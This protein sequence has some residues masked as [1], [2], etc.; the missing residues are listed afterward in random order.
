MKSF[1]PPKYFAIK[2]AHQNF[3]FFMDKG[4]WLENRFKHVL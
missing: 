2:E 3:E 1:T 4:K